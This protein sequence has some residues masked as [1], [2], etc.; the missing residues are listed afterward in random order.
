MLLLPFSPSPVH[1]I[2]TSFFPYTPLPLTLS[3]SLPRHSLRRG[4]CTV[5][6]W[7][8]SALLYT[9]KLHTTQWYK[10]SSAHVATDLRIPSCTLSAHIKIIYSTQSH[11]QVCQT[12]RQY[13]LPMT[14]TQRLKPLQGRLYGVMLISTA[15]ML[16]ELILYYDRALC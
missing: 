4:R 8:T 5:L 9:T 13:S 6:S 14:S 1:H 12:A 16:Q 2:L 7:I 15:V 3:S 10:P 11:I